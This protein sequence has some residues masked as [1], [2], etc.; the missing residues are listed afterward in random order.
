MMEPYAPPRGELTSPDPA[1]GDAEHAP[2]LGRLL[3][4][5]TSLA[6][7]VSVL[8]GAF[9]T[10]QCASALGTFGGLEL[11]P[12]I[13][14]LSSAR[15]F[16]SEASAAAALLALLVWTRNSSPEGLRASLRTGALT[17]LLGAFCALPLSIFT[18]TATGFLV[19]A[20]LYRVPWPTIVAST[21]ILSPGDLV[22]ALG[23][24]LGCLVL[25]CAF[26]WIAFPFM[27]RRSWSLVWRFTATCLVVVLSHLAAQTLAMARQGL[28]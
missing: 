20:W 14:V 2:Q 5:Q 24:L 7:A 9:V 22:A 23:A 4:L 21:N 12:R 1:T 18:V 15:V 6:A 25:T 11:V 19:V 17:A 26:A 10:N 8:L 28:S 13:T 27:A 3:L 16:G